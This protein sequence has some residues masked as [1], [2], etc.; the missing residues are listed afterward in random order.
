MTKKIFAV[1]SGL[2][3]LV[4]LAMLLAVNSFFRENA[5]L[6]SEHKKLVTA[7]EGLE[8]EVIDL[9]KKIPPQPVGAIVEKITIKPAAQAGTDQTPRYTVGFWVVNPTEKTIPPMQ[10]TIVAQ[11]IDAGGVPRWSFW[12]IQIAS[13]PP[14]ERRNVATNP[15]ALG[16]PGSNIE[17]TVSLW[18]QPGIAKTGYQLPAVEKTEPVPEAKEKAPVA[19]PPVL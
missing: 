1:I 3:L 17:V 6:L 4:S 15:L 19:A 14:G 11:Q 10:G 7:K 9:K 18:N 16:A 13:I 5:K 8:K 2:F 12:A